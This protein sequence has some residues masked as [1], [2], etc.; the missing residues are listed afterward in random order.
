MLTRHPDALRFRSPHA[1]ARLILTT[2]G[3]LMLPL[4]ACSDK[5]G[6]AGMSG[7]DSSASGE[8]ASTSGQ[9]TEGTGT[10]SADA[11][12]GDGDITDEGV[13]SED[14]GDGDGD[15]TSNDDGMNVFIPV[16]A[17]IRTLVEPVQ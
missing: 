13:D 12:A 15:T 1:R 5:G 9:D 10:G 6:D 2:L 11:S 16:A 3:L 7:D 14:A 17:R 8:E 4:P